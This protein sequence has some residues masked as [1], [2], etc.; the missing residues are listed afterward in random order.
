MF[1]VYWT[2]DGSIAL[3]DGIS[4][5]APALT[6]QTTVVLPDRWK[7]GHPLPPSCWSMKPTVRPSDQLTIDTDDEWD[8]S[9]SSWGIDRT[10]PAHAKCQDEQFELSVMTSNRLNFGKT[11]EN[12][13]AIG[14]FMFDRSS[15]HWK[16][17]GRWSA[18]NAFIWTAICRH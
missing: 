3:L 18:W 8:V 9:L 2:G 4:G 15:G 10:L 13:W 1:W 5:G 7:R 14:M 17:K 12:N 6:T 11:M 16:V